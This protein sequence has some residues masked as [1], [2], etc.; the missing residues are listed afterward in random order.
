MSYEPKH[1]EKKEIVCPF[2]F[3]IPENGIEC[4]PLCGLYLPHQNCCSL[5]LLA[6]KTNKISVILEKMKNEQ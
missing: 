2:K 4:N 6:R 5:Q 3:T 1:N